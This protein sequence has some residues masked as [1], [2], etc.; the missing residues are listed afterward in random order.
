[1][2]ATDHEVHPVL[3]L[4]SL[5][6]LRE[7]R[8]MLKTALLG[9]HASWKHRPRLS[10][11]KRRCRSPIIALLESLY[12]FFFYTSASVDRDTSTHESIKGVPRTG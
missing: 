1:M 8:K 10:D 12:T 6:V 11:D 9:W 7:E 5:S 2:A 4:L 3:A